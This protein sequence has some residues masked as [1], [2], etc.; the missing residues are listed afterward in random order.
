MEPQTTDTRLP[1]TPR[2]FPTIPSNTRTPSRS[3]ATWVNTNTPNTKLYFI[4]FVQM[5][6]LEETL[7]RKHFLRGWDLALALWTYR[8][9]SVMSFRGQVAQNIPLLNSKSAQTFLSPHSPLCFYARHNVKHQQT[10]HRTIWCS[11]C[12]SKFSLRSRC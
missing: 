3:K 2:S 6:L 5:H 12:R 7:I 4:V 8:A 1:I 11:L 10:A 9:V